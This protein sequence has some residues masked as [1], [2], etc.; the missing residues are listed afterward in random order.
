MKKNKTIH[1]NVVNVPALSETFK[2]DKEII[3]NC[4]SS[5]TEQPDFYAEP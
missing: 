1:T 2:P 5:F 4:F 3:K